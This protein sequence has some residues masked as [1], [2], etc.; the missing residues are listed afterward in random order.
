V[1]VEEAYTAT[2][3]VVGAGSGSA[4]VRGYSYHRQ[5]WPKSAPRRPDPLPLGHGHGCP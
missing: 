4:L 2:V 3:G 5:P 1:A